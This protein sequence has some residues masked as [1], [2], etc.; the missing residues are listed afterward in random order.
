[1][2][3]YGDV[4]LGVT[5]DSSTIATIQQVNTSSIWIAGPNEDE[6]RA[7]LILKTSLADSVA[8]TQDGRLVYASRT[9]ENWDIWM[10]NN[11]GSDVKQLTSDAFIDQQPSATLDGRYIVFQSNRSGTRNLWRM[12]ADGTNLKQ[13][14]EG[15]YLDQWP[16]CSIDG[17]FVIFQSDRSGTSTIWKVGIDGGTPVQLTSRHSEFPSVSPDGKLIA[18]YF[19]DERSNNQPTMALIP[20][21]GGDPVK[22]IQLPETIQSLAFGMSDARSVAYLDGGAGALNIWTQS[23]DGGAPKQ[24]TNF[25]TEFVNSFAFA[26]DGKIAVYRFSATRDIVLIKDFR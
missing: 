2:N 3:G 4:S 9:G 19:T 24:L 8:W 13:L 10:S 11:D 12:D 14:T 17:R 21:E 1:L 5:S 22:T 18:Y 7:R 20:I 6:S 23:I 25:K 15:N 16:A 26:P